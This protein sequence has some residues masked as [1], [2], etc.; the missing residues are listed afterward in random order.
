MIDQLIALDHRKVDLIEDKKSEYEAQLSEWQSFNTQLL[1]LKTSAEGLK[2]PEDFYLYTAGMSTDSATVEAEDLL[3]VSTGTDAASGTY[4]IKVTNLA[5]SE[6]LSS[7]PFTS[8]TTEL[9]SSYAG[10]IIINGKVVTINAT[11]SLADVAYSINNA[12]T[13]TDPSGVT[14]SIINYGTNDYRLILTSDDTGEE[15]ISLLNGSSTDL[16]QKYGWKDNETAVIKNSITNGAQSD[17]FTAH[18]VA[19]KSFLG[20]STGETSTGTLTIGGTAVTINLTTMSLTDVKTAI[21]DAAIAGVTASVVSQTEDGNTYYR[22]QIDGTQTFVDEKNILNTLGVFDHNS[23]DVTGKVSGKSMT[24]EG[25]YITSTTLLKDI[26][27]YNTFTSGGNPAGDYITLTGTNTGGSDIGSVN[28]DISSSTTVQDLLDEIE[29]NYGDVIAYVTSDGKIRVDDLTG[30]ANLTVKLTDHIDDVNSKLEFVDADGFFGAASARKR[31]VIAGEDATV[32]IDGVEVTNSTN[33][34]EDV[35]GGVTLNLV[36]ENDSTNITLKI[37]HDISSIK[38]NIQDFVD[39]YNSVMSYINTQ[40]DY[41]EESEEAGGVLFGDGT[42]HSVKSDLTSLLTK[43]IWGV[44]SDFSVLGLVGIT[45]DNDL[46]LSVDDDKL[47]GYLQTNFN[48]IMSLFVGQ[49]TTSSSALTY[50]GHSRDSEAGE[51]TVHINRAATRGT[52]TGNADLSAGGADETLTITKGERSAEITITNGM[53]LNDIINEINTE[54]DT[55]YTQT[56]VGDE[57][58]Y[59]DAA[60]SIAITSE[61]KWNSMYDSGGVQLSFIDSDIISFSGTSR[62]GSEVSGTYTIS[63]VD[64]DTAQGLLSAIESAFSS[65]VTATIDTSGRIV[66][67]DESGGTSQLAISS[68]S[69]T[70]EGEFFGTVDVTSSAGDGSQEGRYAMAITATKDGN[71]LVLRSDDYG[72]TSFT[73]SQDITGVSSYDHII[74]TTAGNTVKST[75]DGTDTMVYITGQAGESSGTTWEDIYG[76]TIENGDQIT[77]SGKAR[78]GTAGISGTYTITNI[79]TDTVDGLLTAIRTAY[80]AESTTVDVFIRDGK[81]YVEDTTTGSSSIELTLTYATIEGLD[82]GTFT[83]TTERDMD[84]GLINGAVTGLDVAGAINGESATGSGQ[85]LSGDDDN[86]N[87]DGLSVRYTGTSD[88]VDAGTIKL[89]FGVAE[90]FDR[91]LFSITDFVDGYAAFKQD[92][93]QDSINSYETRIEEMEARLDSKMEM[94]INRFVAMELALSKIQSQSDW[95]TGQI[96]ASYSGWM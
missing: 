3:S 5:Q 96:S 37:E 36:S 59:S 34:I 51:Y 79:T 47:T 73:I 87:T 90:L 77:I 43:S 55:A 11:D 40:F 88:D 65:D 64:T 76:A 81:I 70:G 38:G 19:V 2:D 17:R 26:D 54:L 53:N 13:G 7:N 29:T 72:S 31:E 33:V 49:G 68:I 46:I 24:S 93:L 16:V 58:L 12:N 21:N 1:S 94:M 74:Y 41:D 45:M 10:D 56:I 9:G 14:A 35:I 25:T 63:A 42:L 18:N 4:T 82:L 78:N 57:K 84:L 52:E 92:S 61:T 83:E 91:T 30:G 50:I 22:L 89:T 28:F 62:S 80:S 23:A 48:D 6:K 15:G 75:T 8:Q 86:V 67:T 85:V 66:I 71:N 20:L 60:H 95:L 44:D 27:A 32:E 39:K 69:H